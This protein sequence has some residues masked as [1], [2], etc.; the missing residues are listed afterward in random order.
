MFF[1][2]KELVW[3]ILVISRTLLLCVERNPI[4]EGVSWKS[5]PSGGKT[6]IER[7]PEST[8]SKKTRSDYFDPVTTDSW[9]RRLIKHDSLRLHVQRAI[10]SFCLIGPG[11]KTT[12]LRTRS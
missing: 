2:Q 4:Y 5:S 11:L 10:L 1:K 7:L 3:I 8:I 12:C 9:E 6:N